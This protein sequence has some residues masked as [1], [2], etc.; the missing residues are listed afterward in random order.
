[1]KGYKTEHFE[2]KVVHGYEGY[3]DK[4]GAISYPI[5]QSATFRHSGLGEST[6]F[7]YSRLKNPTRSELENTMALLEEGSAGFAFS[8]GMAAISTL[9]KLF[10]SG[11]HLVV[12]DDLYGGTY[13]I[14]K[15]IYNIYNIEVDFVNMS[16]MDAVAKSIR[17]E[18]KALLVETPTN[19]TMKV[20]DIAKVA[21]VAHSKGILLIV[22]NTFLSPYYQKPLTLG[23]DI[24]I[25]SGTKYLGGHNDALAGI[26]VTNSDVLAEKIELIQ[27]SEGAVLSPFD[28][29]LILRGIKT[30]S[31]RLDRQSENAIIIAKWLRQQALVEK[32]F[33]AGL[34]DHPGYEISSKQATGYGAMI[35][36]EVK[37][38]SVIERIL[39]KIKLITFAE[40]LGGVESLMTYP[41]VQ[42][43]SAIPEEVRNRVGVNER[44]LRLSVGIEHVDDLI[45]DLDQALKE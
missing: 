34:K 8:S 19:P 45:D 12:S 18:T 27:K 14:L 37:D 3:D 11:D 43:H 42:T 23:A 33:Y 6:G 30:L 5:Y 28:S 36:F 35:A 17:I 15:D 32:V 31:I 21:E 40:S 10:K 1:M 24:V 2:S 4:T 9:M 20:T 22:D 41:M 38:R 26:V 29:W 7:D 25:H 44:L 13:R 16:D 39:K